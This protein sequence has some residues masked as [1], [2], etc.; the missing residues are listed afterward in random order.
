MV[1]EGPH[2]PRKQS[3]ETSQTSLTAAAIAWSV[4]SR[5]VRVE[6]SPRAHRNSASTSTV[7]FTTIK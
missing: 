2:T 7:L 4:R 3:V 6:R 5:G 1:I